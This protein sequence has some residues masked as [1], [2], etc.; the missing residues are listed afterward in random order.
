MNKNIIIFDLDGTLANIQKR[1][2]L[3]LKDNGKIDWDIFFTPGLIK[4]DL[5]NLPVV[6]MA[7]LLDDSGYKI[8]IFSYIKVTLV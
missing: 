4:Q 6:K 8:Y 5:P 1:R 2:D 3:S 7:Q